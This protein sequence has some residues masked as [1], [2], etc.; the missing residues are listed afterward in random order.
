[1]KFNNLKLSFSIPRKKKFLVYGDKYDA[2]K[3]NDTFFFEIF[4]NDEYFVF[5]KNFELINCWILVFSLIR[6][7]FSKLGYLN[8]LIKIIQPK[9]I[10]TC[11]D[12]SLQ[13]YSLKNYYPSITFISIQNGWRGKKFDMFDEKIIEKYSTAKLNCDYLLCFNESF[14]K[15]YKKLIQTNILNAGS[16]TANSFD[17]SNCKNLNSGI[18]FLLQF[19]PKKNE[20]YSKTNQGEN[21]KW[22]DLFLPTGELLKYLNEF[23]LENKIK[24]NILG[25][26]RWKSEWHE[27]KNFVSKYLT[28]DYNFKPKISKFSSYENA[29][30]SKLIVSISSTL[31]Y[32]MIGIGK[33]VINIHTRKSVFPDIEDTFLWPNFS[34]R[35][36]PFWTEQF[37][38]EKVFE[39]LKFAYFSD[40]DKW[41]DKSSIYLKDLMTR[42]KGNNKLKN[43]ING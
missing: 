7:K 19:R 4:K 11:H 12:N 31:A 9:Y 24:L 28:C 25:R 41:F 32:E 27:E 2:T 8:T 42:D 35:E 15:M 36:G 38:K 10:L 39:L 43:L 20:I 6:L 30:K 17:E 33:R 21:I 37:N 26:S 34:L 22:N 16:V 13:F 29:F 23:C 5:D 1:M 14:G 40:D 3:K 18:S